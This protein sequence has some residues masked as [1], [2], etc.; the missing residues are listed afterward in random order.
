MRAVARFLPLEAVFRT[1]LLVEKAGEL[2]V[3]GGRLQDLPVQTVVLRGEKGPVVCAEPGKIDAFFNFL[4]L[5][6]CLA[7]FLLSVLR[8][9]V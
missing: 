7:G 3:V 8:G 5:R 9:T 2:R 1:L 4:L 6:V